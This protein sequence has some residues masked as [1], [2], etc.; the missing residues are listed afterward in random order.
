LFRF[1]LGEKI[2]ERY[3][4]SD[5]LYGVVAGGEGEQ[6][7]GAACEGAAGEVGAIVAGQRGVVPRRASGWP[8]LR[9]EG[10][11]PGLRSLPDH[12]G[13]AVVDVTRTRRWTRPRRRQGTL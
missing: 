7:V 4:R 9:S 11:A 8:L 3:A 12:R 6:P 2:H 10:V 13:E 5:V 1:A